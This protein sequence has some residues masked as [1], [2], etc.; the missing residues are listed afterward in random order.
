M[1]PF[2]KGHSYGGHKRAVTAD[3]SDAIAEALRRGESAE[4]VAKRFGRGVSTV[5]AIGQ[6]RCT[7]SQ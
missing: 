5:R 2:P 3:E 7:K 4:Q 1:A 6:R